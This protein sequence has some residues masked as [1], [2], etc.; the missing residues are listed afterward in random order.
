MKNMKN[1]I[2][3]ILLTFPSFLYGQ[4]AYEKITVNQV[5]NSLKL[6]SSSDNK[7][8][9]ELTV[10]KYLKQPI[11]IKGKTY[12]SLK[13]DEGNLL[14]QKGKPE[15]PKITE[16]IL[17]PGTSGFTAEVTTAEYVDIEL[18]VVP[19]KG[20]LYRNENPDDVPYIFSDVYSKNTFFP[21]SNFS[22]GRPYLMRDA[23]G[24]AVHFFPFKYNPVKKIVRIFTKI[25]LEITFNGKNTINASAH[26]YPGANKYFEPI[27]KNHF[28]NYVPT[29]DLKSATS[30]N[31][32]GKMLIICHSDFMDE[33]QDFINHKNN[34]GLTTEIVSMSNVGSTASDIQTYIQNNYNSDNSL[35]FVLLVGDHDRVPSKKVLDNDY[36]S[37]PSFS[38][39]NGTDTIPDIIIGRFSAEYESEV[40]TMV[41]R[42]INYENSSDGAWF[43]RG[44]G[45]ASYEDG[46]LNTEP[47]YEHLQSIRTDLISW[48]YTQIAEL[49]QGSQG[50]EDANGDPLPSEIA[51]VIN[52]GVSIINYTGHGLPHCWYLQ[53]TI[54]W[55]NTDI[56]NINDVN[57]LTN[58]EKLPFVF[59]VSCLVGR[60]TRF[61]EDTCFAESWLRATYNNKPAGAIGFYGS[62]IPQPWEQPK[63]AQ[64]EFNNLLKNQSNMAFGALCYSACISMMTDYSYKIRDDATGTFLHWNIFGDPSVAVIPNCPYNYVSGTIDNDKTYNCT[65]I[66]VEN[67]IIQNNANVIFDAEV[68]KEINKSFNIDTGST[69]EIK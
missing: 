44:A 59:S 43:H 33:M 53:D 14:L 4:K 13:F 12:Y 66:E 52:N 10:G 1:I 58:T 56:Y 16:N 67:T 48:H 27:F 54:T 17:I 51:N 47:D 20:T 49:Y 42:T 46:P 3:L 34:R 25:K 61:G 50:G 19:S 63:D 69:L 65:Q 32:N 35:T 30:F 55:V 6:I 7:V 62:S 41:E 24:V 64:A 36:G 39:V 9:L 29:G 40:I 38:L 21:E 8:V 15:L 2:I 31:D 45:I 37:D 22:I 68:S 57:S 28:I 26:S 23:R 11:Q 5:D 18:E 60:F